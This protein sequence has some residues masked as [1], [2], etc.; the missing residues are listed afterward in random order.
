M[1][2]AR[3]AVEEGLRLAEQPG[4]SPRGSSIRLSEGSLELSLGDL[5][6]A[7]RC[8][9][10]LPD[11][12]ERHGFAEP[13]IFRFH[14][15][16]IETLVARGE[17]A[18]A[19]AQLAVLEACGERL[20]S[21]WALAGAARCRGLLAAARGDEAGAFAEFESALEGH[22]R[23]GERFERART[24]LVY[25]IALRRARRKRAAREALDEAERSSTGSARQSGSRAARGERARVS[26][27]APRSGGLTET[28]QR[29][30]DLATRGDRTSRS[31][32]SSTSP[33]VPSSPT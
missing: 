12:L 33:C 11:D 27:A 15:D 25:G 22:D 4:S 18:E 24:L 5:D 14:P 16:L 1:Q 13:A 17:T 6:A 26:G 20:P 19:E 9:A 2:A 7:Y 31:P 30:M 29:I 32:P 23:A 8:L 3:E 21:A 28:E 10:P